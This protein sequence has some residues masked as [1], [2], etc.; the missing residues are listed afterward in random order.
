MVENILLFPFHSITRI[1]D[2]RPLSIACAH[3]REKGEGPGQE[4]MCQK[5]YI[6]ECIHMGM[7][8]GFPRTFASQSW[9]SLSVS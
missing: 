1:F 3:A 9:L 8:F 2:Y 5:V 6:C 4:R 7:V